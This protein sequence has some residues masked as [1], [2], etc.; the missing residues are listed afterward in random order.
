MSGGLS[1]ILFE[2]GTLKLANIVTL[3]RGIAILPIVAL[4]WFDLPVAALILYLVAAMTDML[5]GWLARRS[6][7]W[8]DYGARLDAIVDN[9]FSMAIL[10]FLLMAFPGLGARHP[11]ALFVLFGGP[12][13]YLAVSLALTGRL[14]MFHFWSAKLGAL[15]LFALWPIEAFTGHEEFLPFAAIIV[16]LSRIEQVLFILRGGRD[17]DASHG[18]AVPETQTTSIPEN[19]S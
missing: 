10:A 2:G 11:I 4:L 18:L 12:L 6:S 15:L 16:G 19:R 8:S 5:D 7:R 17:L 14:M 3:S 9:L 1:H 13:I